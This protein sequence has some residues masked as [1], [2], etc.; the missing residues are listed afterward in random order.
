MS[1]LARGALAAAVLVG[2]VL[3]LAWN[4]PKAEPLTAVAVVAAAFGAKAGI[5]AALGG[6]E[7]K[8]VQGDPREAGYLLCWEVDRAPTAEIEQFYRCTLGPVPDEGWIS[9]R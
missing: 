5:E 6:P 2:G 1:K 8:V 4:Q 9:P 3:A 7:P